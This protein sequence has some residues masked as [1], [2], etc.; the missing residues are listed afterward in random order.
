MTTIYKSAR[1][2]PFSRALQDAR[3]AYLA[4]KGKDAR[5]M[6]TAQLEKRKKEITE[7]RA[8]LM[9]AAK[10]NAVERATYQDYE[11]TQNK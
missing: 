2:V 11:T 8:L 5:K 6:S 7:Y 9:I 4:G 1:C 3:N 10:A